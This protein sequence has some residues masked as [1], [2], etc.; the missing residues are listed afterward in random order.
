MTEASQL[1]ALVALLAFALAAVFGGVAHRVNFCTMGAVT[2]IANFGDWRR[3]RMWLLAIATAIVGTTILT[4]LGIIDIRKTIYTP[5]QVPWLSCAVGGALFGFGMTLA[6]GCGSKTL[7]RVG[8]GNLKSLIVM[9]FL[10][11][12]AYMTLRGFLAPPRANFFDTF[13]L[14]LSPLGVASSDLG[15]VG[16]ALGIPAA[17]R[18]LPFVVAAAIGAFVLANRDCRASRERIIGGLVIGLVIVGGWYISGHIGY[19]AEDPRTLEEKFVATNSG[20]MESYSFTAPV[21]YLIELLM[22][23][24][25]TSRIVTFGIA[26]VLGLI[27]GATFV[28]LITRT[29][30]WEGFA[31]I[32]D[33]G[34]HIVGGILMGFGGVTALGCTIGQGLT[35]MST[36]AV[37]SIITFASIIAGCLAAVRYQMWRIERTT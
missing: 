26:G 31:N 4:A 7:L 33:L 9:L 3:M 24:T 36:L 21:A 14:D 6:S 2:D 37:G 12:S 18:W 17:A 10:G 22:F 27:A 23:W 1:M 29:F 8:A 20:R 19:L 11:L 28:A 16:S 30:R 34:N 15:T 13:R 25:D 35:G 5:A 32:E